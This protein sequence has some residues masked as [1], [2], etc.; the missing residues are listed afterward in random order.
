MGVVTTNDVKTTSTSGYF[1]LIG[2]N[3][4]EQL[5]LTFPRARLRFTFRTTIIKNHKKPPRVQYR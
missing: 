3:G 5:D 4:S 1:Y 2:M